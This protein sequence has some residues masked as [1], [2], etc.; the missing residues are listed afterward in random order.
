MVEVLITFNNGDVTDVETS[1]HDAMNVLMEFD[2]SPAIYDNVESIDVYALNVNNDYDTP[3]LI[4]SLW[5]DNNGM[6]HFSDYL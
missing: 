1:L 3:L 5:Y 6:Y 4:A 2:N